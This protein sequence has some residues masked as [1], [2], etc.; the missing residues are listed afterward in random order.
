METMKEKLSKR[1]TIVVDP[2][3]K[4]WAQE[5]AAKRKWTLSFFSHEVMKEAME[6]EV[7]S[8]GM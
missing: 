5:E 4:K 3:V 8:D 6:R 1:I 2:D 7:R